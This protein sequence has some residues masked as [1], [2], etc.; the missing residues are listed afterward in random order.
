MAARNETITSLARKVN[1]PVSSLHNCFHG[2]VPRK[3]SVLKKLADFFEIS[4]DELVFEKKIDSV[5]IPSNI[6]IEGS[7]EVTIRRLGETK[8]NR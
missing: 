6:G 7:F 2:M 5:L 8:N 3:L 4:I 1:I